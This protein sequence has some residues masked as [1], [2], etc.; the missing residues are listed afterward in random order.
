[1]PKAPPKA[2]IDWREI[3]Q[4]M[5]TLN[6]AIAHAWAPTSAQAKHI[7]KTRAQALA[8]VPQSTEATDAYIAVVEF[9]LAYER[10]AI[11][12]RWVRE[13]YPLDHFTPLPCTPPF[14]LGI[15]NLRGEILSVIDIKRF[16]DLSEKG[17]TDLNQVIVLQS[18]AMTFGVLADAIIGTR[19][20]PITD[21][22]PSLP[23]LTGI[24]AQYLR[25]VTTQCTVILDAEKLLSDE[26][27][28]VREQVSG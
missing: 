26:K 23:T 27:I 8:R 13:V 7:L 2:S 15:V 9:S 25:G 3:E 1:M 14:V 21:I 17:L 20:I 19:H 10:Y 6:A 16:F 11:E 12:S 4:R 28:V 5:E 24:R 18:G 22:Q